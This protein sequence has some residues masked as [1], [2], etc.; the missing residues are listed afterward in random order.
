MTFPRSKLKESLR[1]TPQSSPAYR[2]PTNRSP[3]KLSRSE[4]CLSLRQVIGTTALSSTAIDGLEHPS[5]LA[6]VAGAAAV[7]VSFDDQLRPRQR[8]FRAKPTNATSFPTDS[9][10]DSPIPLG[11]THGLR[12]GQISPSPRDLG[13]DYGFNIP[14]NDPTDTNTTK[15]SAI[16]ERTKPTTCLSLS[17]DGSFLA[18]GE[19]R[20]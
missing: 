7:V 3:A 16:R 12:T 13:A 14:F 1:L 6:F 18:V 11:G 5:C 10:F 20:C 8:C 17:P 19:V 4:G 15:G 9:T 2:S